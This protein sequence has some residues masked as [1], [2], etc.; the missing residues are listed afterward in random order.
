[1]EGQTPL[2]CYHICSSCSIGQEST[3]QQLTSKKICV[4]WKVDFPGP[5]TSLTLQI[6]QQSAPKWVTYWRSVSPK[7]RTLNHRTRLPCTCREPQG[8]ESPWQSQS[9]SYLCKENMRALKVWDKR[10]TG[11]SWG[12]N[13]CLGTL[14]LPPES[15]PSHNN[16]SISE[17]SSVSSTIR[18]GCW[19]PQTLVMKSKQY[20]SWEAFST[21]P[22]EEAA[23]KTRLRFWR[24]MWAA[25]EKLDIQPHF[26]F[27]MCKWDIY[28]DDLPPNSNIPEAR[29][30][31]AKMKMWSGHYNCNVKCHP[32]AHSPW[33]KEVTGTRTWV[34]CVFWCGRAGAAVNEGGG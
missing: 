15:K 24:V 6:N 34:K 1:M 14:L 8:P 5:S 26:Q 27:P 11:L 10:D 7:V 25:K 22:Q 21:K 12:R 31:D 20:E 28:S 17:H 2:A 19:S 16:L 3:V 23:E 29:E 18:K 9:E 33:Q 13:S 32:E 30:W 4:N